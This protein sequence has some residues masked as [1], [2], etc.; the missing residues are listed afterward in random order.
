MDE[1]AER[2]GRLCAQADGGALFERAARY[3]VADTVERLTSAVRAGEADSGLAADLDVVDEAFAKH[4]IDG[5][6]SGPRGYEPWRG[7]GG[8]PMVVMWACP[9]ARPC[10][11]LVPRDDT[12]PRPHCALADTPFTHRRI[13]L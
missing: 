1:I 7:G 3:G 11:R 13:Q 12:V 9:A 10:S 8:H 6:T 5:L 4:G 2:L